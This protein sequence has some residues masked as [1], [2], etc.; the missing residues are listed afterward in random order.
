M[1][2]TS[3]QGR[4]QE[5]AAAKAAE[6]EAAHTAAVEAA[7]AR[8]EA[9]RASAEASAELAAS[10]AAEVAEAHARAAKVRQ[11]NEAAA[12][13]RQAAAARRRTLSCHGSAAAASL[14]AAVA[15]VD[16]NLGSHLDR[17]R[18][19]AE[20]G[21]GGGGGLGTALGGRWRAAAA[22]VTARA[23]EPVASFAVAATVQANQTIAAGDGSGGGGASLSL[24]VVARESA[25]FAGV[26]DPKLASL[27]AKRLDA[28]TDGHVSVGKEAREVTP[29]EAPGG[30]VQGSGAKKGGPSIIDPRLAARLE[31]QRDRAVSGE[32]TSV[33]T[34]APVISRSFGRGMA[35]AGP[36]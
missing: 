18:T 5:L 33:S 24:R 2:T 30:A 31:V 34:S 16:P 4:G 19:W 36:T 10:R 12:S 28:I 8:E 35:A 1:H 7:R 26:T 32:I 29:R 14:E 6:A 3:P 17:Q 11:A 20:G 22:A 21:D 25:A 15:A 13:A 27:L 9:D 23:G